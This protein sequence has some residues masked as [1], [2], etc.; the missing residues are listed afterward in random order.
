MAN[1]F[2]SSSLAPLTLWTDL[3]MR[4]LD[5]TLSSTQNIGEGVDRLAR[6]AASVEADGDSAATSGGSDGAASAASPVLALAKVQRTSFDMMMNGWLQWMSTLGT[7][8]SLAV[9]RE[10]VARQQ[11]VLDALRKRLQQPWPVAAADHSQAD[12]SGHRNGSPGRSEA[13]S[14]R[15]EHAFASTSAKAGRAGG[16]AKRKARS[17]AA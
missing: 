4:A 10:F 2:T 7:V 1:D 16:R 9:G 14:A 3:G 15:V 5:M 13:A 8:A 6:A 17:S 12:P 11:P